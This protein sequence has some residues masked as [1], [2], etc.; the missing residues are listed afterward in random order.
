MRPLLPLLAVT[1]TPFL[2]AAQTPTPKA[3]QLAVEIRQHRVDQLL[4]DIQDT[5]DR[6]E[7]RLNTVV[8]ALAHVTDSKDSRVRV[9]RLKRDAANALIENTEAYIQR[10][11]AIIEQVRL[12]T[13]NLTSEQKEAILTALD[14]KVKERV[15][16]I[17]KIQQSFPS[18]TDYDQFEK[19]DGRYGRYR[20]NE[21]QKHNADVQKVAQQVRTELVQDIKDSI[22]SREQAIKDMQSS[23]AQIQ[24]AERKAVME[25]E[26]ERNQAVLDERREQLATLVTGQETK[27]DQNK[28]TKSEANELSSTLSEAAAS[29]QQETNQL[30]RYYSDYIV[31]LQELNTAKAAAGQTK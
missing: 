21:T 9:A 17:L 26:I 15:D 24:D 10:R 6:L 30:F 7:K 16:Q 18:P 20:T 14:N 29:L 25:K 22:A 19:S 11:N 13:T 3:Q 5:D 27:Q 31:A 8:D 28:L 23:L 12:P 4:D 2:L 1:L